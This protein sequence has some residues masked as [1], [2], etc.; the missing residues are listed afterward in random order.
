MLGG[1]NRVKYPENDECYFLAV[2]G[3]FTLEDGLQLI[4]FDVQR[5]PFPTSTRRALRVK[6][7]SSFAYIFR[8]AFLMPK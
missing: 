1:I 4:T 7:M 2:S 6:R 8:S 5:T 3:G